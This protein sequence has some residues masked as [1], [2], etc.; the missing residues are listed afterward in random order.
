MVE[1]RLKKKKKNAIVIL[2]YFGM[3]FE[4]VNYLTCEIKFYFTGFY[5]ICK[6]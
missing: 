5:F 6:L 3:L 1:N 4:R 2:P